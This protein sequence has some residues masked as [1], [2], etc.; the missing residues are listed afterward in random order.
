MFQYPWPAEV[1]GI[2]RIALSAQGDLQRVLRWSQQHFP[3]NL[4]IPQFSPQQRFLCSSHCD[5]SRLLAHHASGISAV[6]LRTYPQS[7]S[8]H[9]R[10]SLPRIPYRPDSTGPPPMCWQDRLHRD[11]HC[12]HH[13]SRMCS[14]FPPRKVRHRAN[15]PT[16]RKSPCFRTS[17]RRFRR[18]EGSRKA[19]LLF[20]RRWWW[21]CLTALEEVHPRYPA[22]RMWDPGGVPVAGDVP[23][24]G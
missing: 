21:Y 23:R 6:R 19:D 3:F 9:H 7:V 12:P 24:W 18:C 17:L 4:H 14:S 11:V 2:E 10:V 20:F 15:V 13:L 16:A 22:L 1:N 5:C 8:E